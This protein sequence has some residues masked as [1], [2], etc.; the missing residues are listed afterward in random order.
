M[1]SKG[2][3]LLE[4]VIVLAV[5]AI[6]AMLAM[7]NTAPLK[8]RK[9]VAE[10]V[11]YADHYKEKIAAAYIA[12]GYEFPA[13]NKLAGMPDAD[14]LV[15][16]QISRVELQDG[17]MHITLGNNVFPILKNKIISIQPLTVADSPSS[18]ID[19]RCGNGSI[20]EGM[21]AQG[22]N[23]TDISNEFLPMNCRGVATTN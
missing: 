21:Q 5:I 18:P 1:L 12:N 2:F 16:N 10:V 20:P 14:K 6:L 17:V 11:E 23:R 13:T 4:M 7:P 9:T 22:N 19:W 8:A 3:T 15:S